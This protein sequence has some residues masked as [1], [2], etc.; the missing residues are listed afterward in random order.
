M[1]PD[2]EADSEAGLDVVGESTE[3]RFEFRIFLL[4]RREKPEIG[5]CSIISGSSSRDC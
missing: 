3:I 1:D 5:L 2:S 4:S